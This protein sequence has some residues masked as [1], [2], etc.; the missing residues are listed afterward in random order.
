[1]MVHLLETEMLATAALARM[2]LGSSRFC[3]TTLHAR[4]RLCDRM[5]RAGLSETHLCFTTFCRIH[6]GSLL[7]PCKFVDRIVWALNLVSESFT[8]MHE[9]HGSAEKTFCIRPK[10]PGK[11]ERL[12]PSIVTIPSWMCVFS[13]F[14]FQSVNLP[15]WLPNAMAAFW[16]LPGS[17]LYLPEASRN[18]SNC[19]RWAE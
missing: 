11:G 4:P 16:G 5:L 15:K 17:C 2:N 18:K 12:L 9:H 19:C 1:M 10:F 13:G 14:Q 3:C 7:W 8:G 6:K